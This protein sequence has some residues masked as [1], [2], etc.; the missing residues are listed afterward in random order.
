[1]TKV[2]VDHQEDKVGRGHREGTGGQLQTL[3]TLTMLI[4]SVDVIVDVDADVGNVD[5][6]AAEVKVELEGTLN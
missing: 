1:M 6:D 5:V 4:N 3:V 2:M